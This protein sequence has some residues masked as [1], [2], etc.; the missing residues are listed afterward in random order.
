LRLQTFL[1]QF[2]IFIGLIFFAK[3]MKF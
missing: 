2:D 3:E 1:F